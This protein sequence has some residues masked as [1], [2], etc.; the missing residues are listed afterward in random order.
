MDCAASI[1]S[2]YVSAPTA[3]ELLQS[4]RSSGRCQLASCCAAAGN[5]CRRSSQAATHKA[6]NSHKRRT[7]TLDSTGSDRLRT[8]GRLAPP[9]TLPPSCCC[10]ASLLAWLLRASASLVAASLLSPC[11]PHSRTQS[12]ASPPAPHHPA[13]R[14]LR[15]PWLRVPTALLSSPRRSARIRTRIVA[16]CTSRA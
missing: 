4:M 9:H 12:A 2:W 1:E 10:R 7:L 14:P 8:P 13:L 6:H 3:V 11:A 15:M 5:E 16:S